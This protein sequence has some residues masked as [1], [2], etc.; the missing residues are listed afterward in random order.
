[1]KKIF[2]KSVVASHDLK[3]HSILRKKDIVY[4]SSKINDFIKNS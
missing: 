2:E 1:M 4:I 3:A